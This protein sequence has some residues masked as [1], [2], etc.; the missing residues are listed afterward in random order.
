MI[1]CDTSYRVRL[2]LAEPGHE[3]VRELC[4]KDQVAS[5]GHALVEVPAALHRAFREGRLASAIF[6]ACVEQFHPCFIPSEWV[7]AMGLY[8]QLTPI[9]KLCFAQIR[10]SVTWTYTLAM[11]K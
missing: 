1:Y 7:Q 2:Y 8:V 4:Y 10:P 6:Q 5:A 3:A 11:P 9:L